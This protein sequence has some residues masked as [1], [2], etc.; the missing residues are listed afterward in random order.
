MTRTKRKCELTPEQKLRIAT[1]SAAIQWW[2]REGR[3]I[4]PDFDDV[5]WRDKRGELARD[6]FEAGAKWERDRK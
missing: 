6:A 2:D 4:D 1:E 3:Y 5:D